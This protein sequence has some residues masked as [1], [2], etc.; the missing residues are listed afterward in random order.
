MVKSEF[1]F[2]RGVGGGG[3]FEEKNPE[4]PK[5]LMAMSLMVKCN[6]QQ[7]A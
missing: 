3:A 7:S 1:F 6:A 2:F 4:V 5:W